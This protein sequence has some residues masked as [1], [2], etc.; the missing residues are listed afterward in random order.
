MDTLR[1]Q[2]IDRKRRNINAKAGEKKS[3]RLFC[4]GDIKEL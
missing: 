3:L 4:A 2:P 1:I